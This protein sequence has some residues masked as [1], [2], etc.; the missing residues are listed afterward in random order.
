MFV[1]YC[2]VDEFHCG[3]GVCIPQSKVCDHENHCDDASDESDCGQYILYFL[4]F[5]LRFKAVFF[6]I[7]L[8]QISKPFTFK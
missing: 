3:F 4:Q 1:A 5:S 7:N 8:Y 2:E 6:F